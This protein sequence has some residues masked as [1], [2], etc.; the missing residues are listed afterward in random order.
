MLRNPGHMDDWTLPLA[1]EV[2]CGA[3]L[4]VHVDGGQS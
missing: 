4:L 1:L 2:V 3:T